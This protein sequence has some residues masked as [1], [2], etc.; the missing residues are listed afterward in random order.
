MGA[1][2]Q[3]ITASMENYL[4]AIFVL[5]E[6]ETVARAKDIADRMNGTR[7]SVSKALCGLRDAGY[8]KHEAYGYVALT[9]EGR[10]IAKNVYHRHIA[11]RDFMVTV[12]SIDE[13]DAD[14]AACYMEHGLPKHVVDR[15]ADFAEFVR[16]CP[17]EGATWTKGLGY[18][19][20][21]HPDRPAEGCQSCA[22]DQEGSCTSR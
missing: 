6:D 13:E 20:D 15:F 14:N 18:R 1:I 8:V 17:Y 22:G 10:R 12:L 21:K 4:E 9:K 7:A 2:S 5:I 16:T 19:C 11:L 3:T